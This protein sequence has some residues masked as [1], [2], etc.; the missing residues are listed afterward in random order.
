MTFNEDALLSSRK[1]SPST[2]NLQGTS[3]K[4]ELELKYTA[5]NADISSSSVNESSVDYHS[6]DSTASLVQPQ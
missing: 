1:Q 6:D 5:P 3:K 2:S 4:V